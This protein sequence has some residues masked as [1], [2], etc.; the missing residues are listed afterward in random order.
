MPRRYEPQ[1]I[2]FRTFYDVPIHCPFCG[3]NP[4]GQLR[5]GGAP[6]PCAHTLFMGHSEGWIHISDRAMA[7]LSESGFQLES[8]VDFVEL[9]RLGEDG[10]REQATLEDMMATLS[11]PDCVVFEQIVGP[12]SL[13]S[14]FLAFAGVED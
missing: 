11:F 1:R 3:A 9:Y 4:E 7:Q 14:A 2:E 5:E 13:D 6:A 10:D 8:D 12:P